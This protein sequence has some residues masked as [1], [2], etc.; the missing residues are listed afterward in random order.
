MLAPTINERASQMPS[1]LLN[2]LELGH[3]E[4]PTI[5]LLHGFGMGHRMWQ[6]QWATF[7]AH[8]HLLA[9]DLPGF[10][11][12]AAC[13]PFSMTRATSAI[14]ELVQT[15]CRQP[16]HLC[17]LSL[18]AMVALQ[19][20]LEAPEMVASLLL[21]GA[22]VQPP[23]LLLGAQRLLMSFLPE[24]NLLASFSDFV[25][26][27][28]EDLRTAARE[29][30]QR[31]GKQG[32]LHIL[33]EVGRTSFHRELG[34]IRVPTLVLCGK[35]DRWNLKAAQDLARGVPGA[36]LCIIP[37]AGH[38]WN[39]QMPDLF[40]HTIRAFVQQ[41]ENNRKGNRQQDALE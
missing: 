21:S 15:H 40:T 27:G 25:P 13:G 39:L 16:V 10:A 6:P 37:E 7:N 20:A 2:Y 41:V 34:N 3:P 30:G 11:G 35:K 18:G 12:S 28:Y 38:L 33:R 22:Q 32:L 31:L 1:P 8:F 14:I 26:Q 23:S 17:G 4:H 19:V 29:D 5:V 9:P 24:K 36:T